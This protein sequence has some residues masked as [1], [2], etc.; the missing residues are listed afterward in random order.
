MTPPPGSMS[1]R[2]CMAAGEADA[3][4]STMASDEPEPE[5]EPEP[6]A[7]AAGPWPLPS[8]LASTR[9]RPTCRETH[10]NTQPES[11]H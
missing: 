4:R 5:P 7:D 11:G 2:R 1:G 9:L 10:D 6:A 3:L 8:R